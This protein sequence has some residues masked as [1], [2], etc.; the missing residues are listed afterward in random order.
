MKKAAFVFVGTAALGLA[1][2]H[3]DNQDQVNNVEFNQPSADILNEQANEAAADAANSAAAAN[4]AASDANASANLDSPEDA[5][6][7]N[8]SGM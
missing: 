8:V 5:Q 1:A 2:C 6:E 3:K 7:R 4:K